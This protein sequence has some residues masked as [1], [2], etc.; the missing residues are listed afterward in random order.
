MMSFSTPILTYHSQN[1]RGHSPADNDHVALRMDLAALNDAGYRVVPLALLIDCIE[2]KPVDVEL[3]DAVCLTFDD[4]CDFD[5]SD[6][7][8]PGFGV[9]R[10]FLGIMQDFVD[11]HGESA[12]PLLHASTFVIASDEARR[13]IDGRSLFGKGW[14]S[15][16]WW[17]VVESHRMLSVG[18]HGWD[19][20]HPDIDPLDASRGSFTSIETLAQCRHQVVE[21]AAVIAQKT[22]V[23]P[24]IFAYPFGES[25][26]YIREQYLPGNLSE[27]RC[28]AALGTAPGKVTRSSDRWNLPRYVCGRDWHSPEELLALVR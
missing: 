4:G 2:G 26:V 19:H 25:S 17:A 16:G 7:E 28:R 11:S 20:N 22:G 10:S 21:A 9:Q 3:E 23:W 24:D 18:N 14:I 5:V 13:I 27:H 15:D 1:V 12:Q 8:Y 6:L